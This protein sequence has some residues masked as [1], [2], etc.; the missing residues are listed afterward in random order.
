[1]LNTPRSHYHKLPPWR[2]NVIQFFFWSRSYFSVLK[3]FFSSLGL[4]QLFE[5]EKARATNHRERVGTFLAQVPRY[6]FFLSS[7]DARYKVLPQGKNLVSF[8]SFLS[9]RRTV[10]HCNR[11][12]DF[13]QKNLEAHQ[14]DPRV[15]RNSE[16]LAQTLSMN[17]RSGKRSSAVASFNDSSHQ[18]FMPGKGLVEGPLQNR[19]TRALSL[20]DWKTRQK[21]LG[22]TLVIKFGSWWAQQIIDLGNPLKK[23]CR[24]FQLAKKFALL[25]PPHCC[26]AH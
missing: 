15:C 13:R 18:S 22:I 2:K 9:R 4:T 8:R 25:L 5:N 7:T 11:L 6:S 19:A 17:C 24:T 12:S 14:E 21:R 1:M 10:R 3:A 20:T 23:P 16:N 26:N